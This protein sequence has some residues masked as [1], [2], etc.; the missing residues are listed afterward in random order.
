MLSGN[1][2]NK[3]GMLAVSGDSGGCSVYLDHGM[4]IETRKTGQ[5]YLA[6]GFE[7]HSQELEVV[8]VA[9]KVSEL[10]RVAF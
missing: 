4:C 3:S 10:T 2:V 7:C 8:R 6:K 1:N 9:W 5:G